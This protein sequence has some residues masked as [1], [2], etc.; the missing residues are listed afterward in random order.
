M[1]W[2]EK[3]VIEPMDVWPF[4]AAEAYAKFEGTEIYESSISIQ[5]IIEV[6]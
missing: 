4:G 5:Y 6:I 3:E 1:E 2:R